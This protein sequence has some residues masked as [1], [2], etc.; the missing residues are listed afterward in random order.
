MNISASAKATVPERRDASP[1][2]RW[3]RR[4]FELLDQRLLPAEVRYLVC[5]DADGVAAAIRDMVVRGA[6]AIA[7]AAAYGMALA[8]RHEENRPGDARRK[9]LATAYEKLAGARPTA[10]NLMHALARF[11]PL[12]EGG[13]GVGEFVALAEAIH[14]ED[15]VVNRRLAEA[16]ASE[17]AAGSRILTH[18]NTGALAT[19]GVG[20]AFG[21]I[22]AAWRARRLAEVRFTETRPWLQGARLNAWE[23]ARAGIPAALMTEAAAGGRAL[24]GGVDWLIVGADR[25]AANGDVVNKIGTAALAALTR[26]GG[27]RVMVVAPFATVDPGLACGAEFTLE[28]RDGMEVWRAADAGKIPDGISIANPVFDVTP[29]AEVDLLVTERGKVLPARSGRPDTLTQAFSC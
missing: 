25:I 17:I 20:T 2:I 15:I 27:G 7:I 4:R 8:A 21:V 16:G 14:A 5:A 24:A 1:G 13:A 12:I 9:A 22:A 28:N 29:A 26:R 23:F 19:G 18:C 11:D 6:P 3:D 10:V